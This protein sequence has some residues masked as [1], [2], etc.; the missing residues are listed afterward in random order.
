[1]DIIIRQ[2]E[3]EKYKPDDKL[4]SERELCDIYGVSRMTVRQTLLE[5]ERE[6]Y[7]YK[8]HGLGSFVAP[9]TFNQNLDKLYSF[10]EEMK[11][12]GKKPESIVHQFETIPSTKKI[13]EKLKI[14][15][16]EEV[17][18]IT[19]I[20]LADKE[21]LIYE[22]TYLPARM[23]KGLTK[24][25]LET[26][27]MYDVFRED[28]HIPITKAIEK[29]SVTK[30]RSEE[31]KWLKVKSGEPAMLI[32]RYLFSGDRICEY[33]T[34]VAKGDKFVYTVELTD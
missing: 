13:A 3:E 27:P 10:T 22:I 4:P 33:T 32:K 1:M 29:F 7:I 30:V 6:G 14:G 8:K 26:K 21:P 28:Y 12:L 20:R 2:I 24:K 25:Q 19:R 9:R 31:A 18:K 16:D 11:K 34:S 15:I 5:L 17:H 23:F